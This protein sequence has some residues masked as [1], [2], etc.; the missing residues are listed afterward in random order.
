MMPV[1]TRKDRTYTDK[2]CDLL[3]RNLRDRC[4]S[5]LRAANTVAHKLD[6]LLTT[7]VPGSASDLELV[8]EYFHE[9]NQKLFYVKE[10]RQAY[11]DKFAGDLDL[12]ADFNNWFDPRF[13]VLQ[14]LEK[15][16]RDWLDKNTVEIHLHHSQMSQSLDYE[17]SLHPEDSASQIASHNQDDVSRASSR[18]TSRAS[19]SSSR[20]SI[21][22]ARVRESLKKVSLMAEASN[23]AQRQM[24]QRKEFELSLEKESLELSTKIAVA[25]AKEELLLDV[26]AEG[27]DIL[28][29]THSQSSY[30][31]HSADVRPVIGQATSLADDVCLRSMSVSVGSSKHGF[32]AKSLISQ[33]AGRVDDVCV[34]SSFE[35]DDVSVSRDQ[36]KTQSEV[37]NGCSNLPSQSDVTKRT[38]KFTES[39]SV[40]PSLPVVGEN[41]QFSSSALDSQI[42][43]T[44]DVVSTSAL[45]RTHGISMNTYDTISHTQDYMNTTVSSCH[46]KSPLMA[47]AE[48]VSVNSLNGDIA[49]SSYTEHIP[50]LQHTDH[51]QRTSTPVT[52]MQRLNPESPIFVPQDSVSVSPNGAGNQE[53][54]SPLPHTCDQQDFQTTYVL[55]G[56]EL[57]H[58]VRYLNSHASPPIGH[59]LGDT[60]THP[61]GSGV[62]GGNDSSLSAVM[63]RL[64]DVLVDQRNRLPEVIIEKFS[65]NPLEYDSFVR[66]FDARIASRTR[67]DGERMYYLEQYTSGT[68]K[69]LVRSC[70][71]LPAELAYV[72]A[73][74]KLE[75]RFGDKYL[76]AQSYIKKLEGW[77]VIRNGDVKGLD[78]FTT[79]LIECCNTMAS[80]SSIKELDYPSSLKMVVSKLPDYLQVRWSR[81]ADNLVHQKTGTVTLGAL[82]SFLERENRILLNPV[83]G[84][85]AMTL[86]SDRSKSTSRSERSKN[87]PWT[88]KKSTSAAAVVQTESGAPKSTSVQNRCIFCS[89]PH[90]FRLCRKFRQLLHKDKI[91]FLM[92]RKMCFDC[93]SMGH[94][95]SECS[96]KSTCEVCQGSH[97]TSLHKSPGNSSTPG[98]SGSNVSVPSV[99]Q[100]QTTNSEVQTQALLETPV[101]SC[102]VQSERTELDTMPIIPVK[103]KLAYS[104]S[105]IVTHAF[106]DSGS[107]DTLITEHLMKQLGANGIKTTIN[108]TTLNSHNMSVPCHAVSNIEICGL[109]EDKYITLPIVYTQESLPV[110]RQQIPTQE[111]ISRW[112]YLSHIDVPMLDAGIGILIG[113]NVPKA[114]EPWEVINS[115]GDGPY[116]VRTLLGWSINGPLRSVTA[117][118]DEPSVTAYRVQVCPQL[119]SQVLKFFNLD[120]SERHVSATG[121]GLSVEDRRFL[122]LVGDRSSLVDGHYEICL[123]LRDASIPMPNNRSLAFQRLKGIKKRFKAD[124]NFRTKYTAFIDDLFVKGHASVVPQEELVRN[125]GGLWYL[126]HHGVMHVQKDKL[127]VV[128][129]ASAKFAGTSLNECLLSGPDL[130]NNLIGVLLRFRQERVA[131]MSDIE[132]MFYQVRVPVEQHDLLRFL[133]WPEGNVENDPIECRMQTHI[134][135]ASSS[136][137]VV[138]YALQK[139]ADDNVA[140]FSAD[141]VETVKTCFYVDDCLKSVASVEKGIRLTAELRALTQRGG[142]RLTKWVSNCKELMSSI[143]ESEWS[144]N[145]KS[146]NLDYES[147]PSEK[148]LGVSWDVEADTLGFCVTPTEKPATRRG[149]LSTVSSLYDPLGMAAPYVLTGKSIVQD[150]CRLKLTWDEWVPDDLCERWR[151][152]VRELSVLDNFCFDRCYK[153]ESFGPLKSA[154]LHHFTDASQFGYGCVSYLRLVNVDGYVHCAFV[155]GKSRVASLK[156]VTIPRMELTAAVVAAKVDAQLRTELTLPLEVSRFWTDST[157]VLGYVKNERARFN[158]FIAN[159]VAVIHEQSASSQWYYVPTHTNPADHASRGLSAESLVNNDLWKK[160]PKFLWETE[161]FWP[162]QP[163]SHPL[164]EGDSEVKKEKVCSVVVKQETC[165]VVSRILSY[166]SDWHKLRRFVALMHRAVRGFRHSKSDNASEC[167]PRCVR[168]SADDLRQAE[169]IVVQWVQDESFPGVV[170]LLQSGKTL[171]KGS[172]LSP[173]NPIVVDGILRVGGRIRNAPVSDDVKHPVILPPNSPVSELLVRTIHQR[174]GHGGREQVLCRLR[175]RYWIIHGNALIRRL[176]RSCVVC[177]RRFHGPVQQKMADLPVDHVTPDQPPFCN[178]GVDYFGPILVKRGRSTVKRYGALFTCLVSRAVHLEMSASLDTDAFINVLR[179]FIARRGQVQMIRSDNG[180]NLV[181]AER[182]LRE[183]IRQWNESQIESFLLQKNITWRFN[184]PGASHHGGTWERLIRSTRRVMLGLVKEQTLSDDGLATLFAEV[185]SVLNS[186]PLTGSSSD[187]NDLTC[188]TPNHLLL[189]KDQCCLPPGIFTESDNYVRRRWR[190]IQYLS[191]LFWKRWTREYLPLLQERQKWLFPSRNVQVGDVVL[192]VDSSAPRGSWLLGRVREVYPDRNGF[193]RNVSLRTKSSTLVRPVSKLVMILECDQ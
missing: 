166:Y 170:H 18:R 146:V 192:V 145:L 132:C 150:C 148:A 32:D 164:S 149:I 50:H 105:E 130:T 129:D 66:R 11:F 45:L 89:F 173:L 20:T 54:H 111:D 37:I 193:I 104:D 16:T 57:R 64:T 122:D 21:K 169:K 15:Y 110:S 93:L 24:L 121:K 141:A 94:M 87:A 75:S 67:D 46:G 143:P 48:S 55:G 27:S 30:S 80:S 6:P 86:K 127:R 180:T 190:Q 107:S 126:P 60:N 181:G 82:V 38:V 3:E 5:T 182:E 51:V 26:E 133:W 109:N 186:R 13:S 171:L 144:K 2:G 90:P 69:A 163:D 12:L 91:A 116:A 159:R 98:Q 42:A 52:S 124:G 41:S 112:S 47:T 68:P 135:G 9:F 43:A 176:L 140:D 165:S 65:G 53:L 177:R 73:R 188:L 142:F 79:F 25:T 22:S 72:E 117:L 84:K 160:G 14:D 174:C 28:S 10:A 101:T 36:S 125:D 103:V 39:D 49:R 151:S 59:S 162:Q 137:A 187:P 1:S 19:T 100:S 58:D 168:L 131:F 95:R 40:A 119:E 161:E 7:S 23:L 134:F 183:A 62:D 115:E 156:P 4:K 147:L 185:E 29:R 167:D 139:T 34:E 191:D 154:Q 77:S 63:N 113:N 153:P 108:L 189:L 83:F 175:E 99:T 155:F 114:N 158:V 179:R 85:E 136:P 8:G 56:P 74:K 96:Q 17:E 35:M 172:N 123:P 76:L 152:W 44:Q 118:G 102:R 106:L 120:F 78:E 138:T 71:H 81:T 88:S 31:K 92:K 61:L 128:F 184:A 178:T 70:M 97:P 33:A 157:S